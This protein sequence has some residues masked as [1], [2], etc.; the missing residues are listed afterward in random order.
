MQ[1]LVA[2]S[3]LARGTSILRE[4]ATSADC[5][6]ALASAELLGAELGIDAVGN[7][8]ITGGKQAPTEA[9]NVGESGLSLRLFTCIGAMSGFPVTLSGEGSLKR[10]PVQAFAPVFEQLGAKFSSNNNFPPVSVHGPFI[11]GEAH[12]DG[13]MSSQFLS[14]LLMALPL[15]KQDTTLF[16]HDLQSKPY[17]DLTLEVMEAYGVEV[18]HQS[19]ARFMI[20]GNQFYKPADVQC[21]GD[22]SSA[23]S[24]L[25]AGALAS[26]NGIEISGLAN[27]FTQADRLV[28]GALLFA[29]ARVHHE[30]GSYRLQAPKLRGIHIDLSDAPDLFPVLA[31]MASA[32]DRPSI[33]TGI[34]RL[35]H[36][37]SNR[38]LTI[39]SEFAKAGIAVDLDEVANTMTVHP[40]AVKPCEIDAH[41][42]HRIA[43]A[44]ALLGLRGGPVTILQADCVSKSYPHFFDDLEDLGAEIKRVKKLD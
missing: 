8:H 32:G 26:R 3:L 43:M 2:A 23:A 1:R 41:N 16:V 22:W 39:Q 40:G 21:D 19:Y 5:I 12:L 29:G 11:G 7:Y 42:D 34:G 38:A 37:E 31:A 9:L 17:I 20:T 6:A 24:L 25:V 36:K 18:L 4:P 10:R 15:A 30:N 14:G 27:R 28:T 33:F 44:A 13:S 35:I